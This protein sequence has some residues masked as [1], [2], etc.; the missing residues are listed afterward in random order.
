MLLFLMQRKSLLWTIDQRGVFGA[1]R[2]EGE[3]SPVP[4]FPI[5][6]FRRCHKSLCW[7]IRKDWTC[8]KK[9]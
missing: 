7:W 2:T 3:C 9:F 5:P 6:D 8:R 1:G 4:S